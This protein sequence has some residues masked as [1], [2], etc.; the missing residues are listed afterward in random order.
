MFTNL[1][2]DFTTLISLLMSNFVAIKIT[3]KMK[4]KRNISICI[5]MYNASLYIKNCIDSI[6]AQ[7]F[8]DFERL[9]VTCTL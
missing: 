1:T 2:T 5:P 3:Q 6:S 7:S 4:S 8:Q 9:V